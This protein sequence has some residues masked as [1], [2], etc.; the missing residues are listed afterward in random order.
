MAIWKPLLFAVLVLNA[1]VR[2]QDQIVAD[3]ARQINFRPSPAQ[4]AALMARPASSGK[5]IWYYQKIEAGSGRVCMD[6]FAIHVTKAPQVAGRDMRAGELLQWARTHLNDFLDPAEASCRV[7]GFQDQWRWASETSAAGAV[8]HFDLRNADPPGTACLGL[9]EQNASWWVL[10]SVHS[11]AADGVDWPVSGNRWFGW[12]DLKTTEATPE[13]APAPS[14]KKSFTQKPFILYTRGA[15]RVRSAAVGEKADA[16]IA[17]EEALWKG[18]IERLKAF[19]IAQ[20]GQCEASALP[21]GVT[22]QDWEPLPGVTFAPHI[23]W[24]DPEG[25]WVST[26]SKKR[27][28]LVINPGFQTCDIIERGGNGREISRTMPLLPAGAAGDGWKIERSSVDPEVLE[29][30]GFDATARQKIIE[31]APAPSFLTFNRK[32]NNLKARWNGFIVERDGK[33]GVAGVKAPGSTLP[34]DYEFSTYAPPA[35]APAP[36]G[37]TTPL[38]TTPSAVPPVTSPP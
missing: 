12:N 26:D 14:A 10:S 33:G 3:W 24:V 16:I 31:A 2:G 13:T 25:S 21:T 32:G 6:Y 1:S 36:P 18:V 8:V 20:G 5:S 37:A 19:I 22:K 38:P 17:R 29:F 15:W 9:A 7:E 34:R 23:N 30:L 27:F 28:R 35:P 11:G 4:Q